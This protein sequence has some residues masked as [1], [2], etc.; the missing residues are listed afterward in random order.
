M[1][2]T[3]AEER[4]IDRKARMKIPYEAEPARPP[5]ERVT[6]FEPTYQSLTPEEA[7]EAASRCIHCPDPAACFEACPAHNNIPLAMWLIEEGDFIGAAEIYRE[8]SSLPDICGRVC[9]HEVLCMASC[10]RYKREEP[11]ITG[12]LEY[13]VADYQRQHSEV[14]IPV[15]EPSGKRVAIIGSGPAGLSCAEQLVRKGHAVTIFEALPS[16]GG[17]LL[18]GIPNF[19]LPK[20][21][22]HAV[23]NDL[24]KA[25]VD[26]VL[27]TR[28]G[29]EKTIDELF[30][31]GYEAVFIGIGT[32][33]DATM[34]VPGIELPGIYPATEF[35]V[36]GNVDPE[37]LPEDI[38]SKPEIGD[39]VV[40]IGG[41][42]TASDCL[43]TALRLGA[44]EVTCLYRR[45]E[46]E[47]PG[48]SKD[49]E[50]TKEEGAK[51]RFLT[52]PVRYIPGP[53]GRV[54][55]VECLQCELGEPDESGRRRPIPIEGSEF[56]VPTDTVILALGYWP[57][58]T[59]GKNTPDL[60]TYDWGLI[61][62]D[63]ETQATSREGIFAGGDAVTG[64][65]LVV[66]AMV[67]GRKAAVSIDSYLNENGVP[68]REE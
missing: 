53:D 61:S 13:F 38:R 20:D 60:E 3:S 26:F 62:A 50:L 52:Q 68:V 48:N 29:K 41:G 67:A 19:K 66:T 9:P 44:K 34:K 1:P 51:Y 7:I 21:V 5:Q 35:L 4:K 56:T 59:I 30:D 65:D 11:V 42:D 6:D 31:Q 12:V 2:V 55:A 24:E 36:R 25:G 63:S 58:E 23:I 47:M 46:A 16:A 15:G 28:I 27:N 45:T 57:D 49:R 18:Y 14:V 8:T 33:V 54:S 22:V 39:R 43:R 37:Y 17:L 10:V 32:G 40:V 64:P